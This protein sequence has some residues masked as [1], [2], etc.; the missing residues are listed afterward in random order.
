MAF[1]PAPNALFPSWAE[2]GTNIT[3]P[4]ASITDL[5]AVEADGTTGDWRAVML[6]IL[7]HV[8]DY[9]QGLATADKPTKVTISRTRRESG[10]NIINEYRFNFST[11]IDANSM[12][13]E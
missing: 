7:D 3:V 11:D 13:S 2:D 8:W 10:A 12:A 4:L 5:T 6:R 9:Q 1:N